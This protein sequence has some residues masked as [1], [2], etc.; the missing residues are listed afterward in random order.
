MRLHLSTISNTIVSNRPRPLS[1]Y[2]SPLKAE[3]LFGY[4]E[5]T[6]LLSN[7]PKVRIMKPTLDK[8]LLSKI[9]PDYSAEMGTASIETL[10]SGRYMLNA[11]MSSAYLKYAKDCCARQSLGTWV[12]DYQKKH[13]NHLVVILLIGRTGRDYST[14]KTR[15]VERGDMPIEEAI[16]TLREARPILNYSTEYVL[17][18]NAC[19]AIIDIVLRECSGPSEAP[20]LIEKP[21][22]ITDSLAAMY[23]KTDILV[24]ITRRHEDLISFIGFTEAHLQ[25]GKLVIQE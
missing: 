23:S 2:L 25:N 21:G 10:N 16:K 6:V 22:H 15:A 12:S 8:E 24:A 17:T 14:I 20:T 1:K 5:I 13:P 19:G 4:F 3:V 18:D 11:G 7:I 9:S